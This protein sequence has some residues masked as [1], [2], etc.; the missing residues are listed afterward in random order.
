[1]SKG[2]KSN[3]PKKKSNQKKTEANREKDLNN[4]P[5][6]G[7]VTEQ[8]DVASNLLKEIGTGLRVFTSHP[9]IKSKISL[10]DANRISANAA[11]LVAV[12]AA[13]ESVR[14]RCP[15]AERRVPPKEME[16][17]LALYLESSG[18]NEELSTNGLVLMAELTQT[19]ALPQIEE[20]EANSTEPDVKEE[21]N[22]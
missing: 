10:E 15:H 3:A 13:I 9:D 14:S 11:D 6:W 16:K 4:R 12:K 8:L 7:D 17:Y 20:E 18:F 21:T 1:M 22:E 5:V 19:Y 2:K